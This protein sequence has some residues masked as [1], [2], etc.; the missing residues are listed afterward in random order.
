M[1][2][3]FILLFSLFF[4][5]IFGQEYSY[6]YSSNYKIE[7]PNFKD[8]DRFYQMEYEMESDFLPPSLAELQKKK[9]ENPYEE[10]EYTI[11]KNATETVATLKLFGYN[12]A[13]AN[14]KNGFLEG[15]KI[16]YHGNQN[17]F[18]VANYNKGKLNGITKYYSQDGELILETNYL[19]G[20]KH[21]KRKYY[22]KRGSEV[23]VEGNYNNGNIIGDIKISNNYGSVIIVPNDMKKGIVK[24]FLSE[25][26]I[27]EY[28]IITPKIIHGEAK[29]YHVSTGKIA[30]ITPYVFGKIH[31]EVAYYDQ[32]GEL[33]S[34]LPYKNNKKFGT[35]KIY[36]QDKILTEE[37]HFDDYGLKTGKWIKYN[38]KGTIENEKYYLND[39]LNGEYINYNTDGTIKYSTTYKNGITN[40]ISKQYKGGK[41]DIET[42]YLNDKTITYKK[43]YSSGE[44]FMISEKV[45]NSYKN[46][47]Y[48]KS[49]KIIHENKYDKNDKAIGIH[50]NY[51]LTNDEIVYRSENHHDESGNKIKYIYKTNSGKVE[52]NYRN[53][54]LHGKVILYN[55]LD[56]IQNTSYYYEA[57]GKSKKVTQEEYESLIKGEKK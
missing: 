42:D 55:D 44:L 15:E 46:T 13:K 9:S 51:D 29:M 38:Q 45:N 5:V 56:E 54:V 25:K 19:N 6:E 28:S 24:Q 41:V 1:K 31:G 30:S 32:N 23:V 53:N 14:Y 17:V 7:L 57:N 3:I 36:S 11:S 26:L 8:F 2:S 10:I 4:G 12:Y 21:G 22:I 43:F 35:H 37:N 16:I 40:G 39:E 50:I 49:G 33:L 34:K 18:R 48:E 27:A 20:S 52:N 47:Y